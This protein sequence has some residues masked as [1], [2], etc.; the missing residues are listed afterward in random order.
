MS[1]KDKKM[2]TKAEKPDHLYLPPLAIW[3]H[4]TATVK[5]CVTVVNNFHRYQVFNRITGAEI[6]SGNA[7][8]LPNAKRHIFK[9]LKT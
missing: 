3:F 9:Y 5:A 2:K 4:T 6:H 7:R 1:Q 8:S